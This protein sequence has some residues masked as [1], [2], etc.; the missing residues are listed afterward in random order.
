MVIEIGWRTKKLRTTNA[1][2]RLIRLA[3]SIYVSTSGENVEYER[4]SPLK[5]SK[6]EELA[7]V[8]M[9]R[10]KEMD[11]EKNIDSEED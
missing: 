6:Y 7:T 3:K 5:K 9:I 10:L 2:L 11:E 1:R 4:L 8:V